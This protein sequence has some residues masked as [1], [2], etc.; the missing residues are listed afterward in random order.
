[1]FERVEVLTTFIS[2]AHMYSRV[3]RAGA[4]LHY[5]MRAPARGNGVRLIIININISAH[6]YTLSQN[7]L[8]AIKTCESF[9]EVTS[10][11][12]LWCLSVCV[13]VCVSDTSATYIIPGH[14]FRI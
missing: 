6:T 11:V 5:E 8:D 7:M 14:A 10:S 1:M 13:C 4:I 3:G 12:R 9:F 2:L